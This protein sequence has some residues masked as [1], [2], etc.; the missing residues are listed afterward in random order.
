MHGLCDCMKDVIKIH[1]DSES[2]DITDSSNGKYTFNMKFPVRR[3]D[4]KKIVLYVDD[5]ELQTKALSDLAYVLNFE[6]VSELNSYNSRTKGNNSVI[7]TLFANGVNGA[8]STDFALNYQAPLTPH[9]INSVPNTLTIK[10]TD[11]LNTG[12]DFSSADN[13]WAL[14]LRLEC[15]Y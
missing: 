12:L 3:N 9:I 14:T 6:N 4:Y 8:R 5:W 1:L 2:S 7:A 11:I 15:Y 10:I 13:F